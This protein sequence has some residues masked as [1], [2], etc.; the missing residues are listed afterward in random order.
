TPGT[1]T[2]SFT[3]TVNQ[4]PV[5]L[6]DAYSVFATG[7]TTIDAFFGLLFND[8]DPENDPLSVVLVTGPQ[9]GTLTFNSDGSFEYTPGSG[10]T[11]TDS[12]TYRANDGY[13]DSNVVE[14]SLAVGPVAW[15]DL[16][17]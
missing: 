12:F 14:V 8:Y 4:A 15:D 1:A 2:A 7:T 5:A 10:F 13:G 6:A 9:Y 17:I 3:V 16:Y 11:G